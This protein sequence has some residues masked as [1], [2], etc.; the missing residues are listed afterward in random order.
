M[1][2]KRLRKIFQQLLLMFCILKKKKYTLLIFQNITQPVKKKK[3]IPLMIQNEEN[4]GRHY[5]A[6]KKLS[7]LLRGI[8][9]KHHGDFYC[10]KL[11]SFF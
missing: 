4:E 3:K 5:L 8:T 10:F 9:L 11:S 7:T 1:I 2:G 6:V